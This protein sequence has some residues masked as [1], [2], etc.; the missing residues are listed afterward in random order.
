M[1]EGYADYVG[2]GLTLRRETLRTNARQVNGLKPY[3]QRM[4]AAY[5]DPA[6]P[7]E[8]G[9]HI[10]RSLDQHGAPR[11]VWERLE[12]QD[13]RARHFRPGYELAVPVE[14]KPQKQKTR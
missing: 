5:P 10:L 12:Q 4:S 9:L 14:P 2:A 1:P 3:L 11:R 6:L 13:G 8:A 7:V